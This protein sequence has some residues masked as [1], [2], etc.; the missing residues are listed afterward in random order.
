MLPD[1]IRVF[2][3]PFLVEFCFEVMVSPGKIAGGLNGS[4]LSFHDIYF[5]FHASVTYEGSGEAS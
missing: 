2:I 4:L 1:P 3:D 5:L